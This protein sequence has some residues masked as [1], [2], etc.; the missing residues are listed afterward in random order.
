MSVVNRTYLVNVRDL[1]NGHV[2]FLL[3]AYLT[4]TSKTLFR[5]TRNQLYFREFV[6]VIPETWKGLD[7]Y[8]NALDVQLD[9]AQIIIDHA[10]PAYG[11]APYVKQYAECG[12]PGLY[13]HLTPSYLLDDDVIHKW[14]QPE[15]TL[16]HEWAHLRWGL[17]DEYPI[18]SQDA[19]F[20]RYNGAWQPTRCSTEVEG[21][22]LNELTSKQCSFDYFTGKPEKTCRFFP[23]MKSNQAVASLM[24]MQYLESIVEFCDDPAT[25]ARPMRHNYL[26]PN[27]QNRLCAYRSSWEVMRKHDDFRKARLPLPDSTD[28]TPVFRYVQVQPRKRALVLDTSGSMTGSSLSVMMRA[29]SNYILSCVETGSKLGIVQFN[30]NATALSPLQQINTETDRQDLIKSL[31]RQADGKTSIGAGLEK[32]LQLLNAMD[33]KQPGG[34]I[35]LITDGKENERP[36]LGDFQQQ[37]Q[38]KGVVVHSLAYGQRAE[39]TIAHLSKTTGGKTFFYSG[40][41][42]STALIDGL[43]ATVATEGPVRRPDT[44]ISLVTEA[45]S[46]F[47]NTPWSGSF[48]MDSTLGVDTSLT[49][50]YSKP[51]NVTLTGP[52]DVIITR[53]THPDQFKLDDDSGVIKI[54]IPRV[55]SV[56]RWQYY[57]TTNESQSDVVISVQ[58]KPRQADGDVIQ[59]ASWLPED[60]SITFDPKQKLAVFAEVTKGRA[61]VLGADVIAVVERPQSASLTI[62]LYDSGMGSDV[63][64]DDGV[65]AAYVLARDLMGDG[66]YNIKIRV[67][68]Q[69]GSTKVVVGGR[70]RASM[71][72]DVT[73]SGARQD[74]VTET[75]EQFQRVTTAG[76]FRVNGFPETKDPVPDLMAPSRITDLRV[77]NFDLDNGSLVLQWT[78]VG[79]DM[80]RGTAARYTL[81]L[82]TDFEQLVRSGVNESVWSETDVRVQESLLHPQP[83]GTSESLTLSLSHL[84]PNDTVFLSVRAVDES[85]NAGELSN[86]VTLSRARHLGVPMEPVPSGHSVEFYLKLLLPPVATLILFLGMIAV[87][88]ISRRRNKMAETLEPDSALSAS[89]FS[90]DLSHMNYRC[91]GQY[92]PRCPEDHETW[93][94]DGLEDLSRSRESL[95]Y[96]F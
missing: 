59:I 27:R 32:G 69:A 94:R 65:Y 85:G 62:P 34:T 87:V 8:E 26:A 83:A 70:G 21:S 72:L 38:H 71:A 67:Q 3:Q 9:R 92:R 75:V 61:P 31:P 19:E 63:I 36:F 45:R 91:E 11:D 13:I 46:V 73:A 57:V 4:D 24:F 53:D 50:S 93:S 96:K 30:T 37:L 80:D 68:G 82:A 14:G 74:L 95:D 29:A 10:N 76:E 1:S 25:A 39:Q 17:F 33:E 7:Y 23:R 78:A 28:T 88:M 79:G 2:L 44:P 35:I 5:A 48:T 6:I 90:L 15:K 42:D 20:Y 47:N 51:I 89:T 49:L 55:A 16:V 54:I 77:N 52:G 66:R 12:Q 84:G 86:I 41:K 58:S 56:G 18:D 64:K 60:N 40:R 81:H 22:I 43:A